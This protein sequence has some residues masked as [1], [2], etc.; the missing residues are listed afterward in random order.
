MRTQVNDRFKKQLRNIPIPIELIVIITGTSV[1][2]LAKL[3]ERFHVPI[4]GKIPEGYHTIFS[5][6]FYFKL[7]ILLTFNLDFR[8][9]RCLISRFL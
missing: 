9:Q 2:Y 5:K 8:L 6:K 1:T 4:I 7:F 3:N